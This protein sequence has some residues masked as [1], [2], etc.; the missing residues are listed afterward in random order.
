MR[1]LPRQFSGCILS[2]NA[3]LVIFSALVTKTCFL[4]EKVMNF[5]NRFD[6][7]LEVMTDFLERLTVCLKFLQFTESNLK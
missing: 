5:G 2:R 3:V 6:R 1:K 4:P 7:F